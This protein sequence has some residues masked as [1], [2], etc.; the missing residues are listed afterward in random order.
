MSLRVEPS[1]QS[2]GVRVTG[3]DLRQTLEP[4]QIAELRAIWLEHHV[5]AFPDQGLSD[6][7]LERFTLA[8][9]GF[10]QDPFFAP[11]PGRN[12]IAAIRREADE[13]SPLFAKTGTPIGAFRPA[14]PQEPA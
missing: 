5:L 8:F 4:A 2:C 10:G 3:V 13:Q 9:G 1:G 7:D 12:H 6:D 14:L 11:I